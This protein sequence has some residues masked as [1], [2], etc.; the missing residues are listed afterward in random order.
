MSSTNPLANIPPVTTPTTAQS[1]TI[2]PS[3]TRSSTPRQ[4]LKIIVETPEQSPETIVTPEV[5]NIPSPTPTVI[6]TPKP[7]SKGD[8]LIPQ[9]SYSSETRDSQS[10]N[11]NTSDVENLP[12]STKGI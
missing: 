6:N 8:T 5:T 9:P 2:V 11:R 12:K 10:D 7:G 3:P 4:S 1:L